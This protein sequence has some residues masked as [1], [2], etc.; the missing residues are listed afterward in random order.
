MESS[1]Y[2]YCAS[3]A[4]GIHSLAFGAQ[5]Q[6]VDV[7]QY[8]SQRYYQRCIEVL[9]R[10][11][12][13]WPMVPNMLTKL[14]E[15]DAHSESYAHLFNAAC[16]AD[17]LDGIAENTLWSLVDY[18]MLAREVP[19]NSPGHVSFL[20]NLPSPSKWIPGGDYMAASPTS[21]ARNQ[22]LFVGTQEP[23]TRL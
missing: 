23:L 12:V 8:D 21:E 6:G 13:L 10:L 15:F 7:D 16:L 17:E 20:S 1:F 4:A 2:T 18:G 19:G 11:G 9:E 14:R 3:I 22:L 5:H